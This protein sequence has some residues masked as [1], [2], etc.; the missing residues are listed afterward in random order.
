[1]SPKNYV[2]KEH[3]DEVIETINKKLEKLDKLDKLSEQMD[4]LMGKYQSHDEEHTLLNNKVSEHSDNLE[5][6][7]EKL[8]ITL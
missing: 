8:G 3:F 5:I 7:N 6:I 1:M 2:T 4:W